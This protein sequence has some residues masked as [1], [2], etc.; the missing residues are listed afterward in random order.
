MFCNEDALLEHKGVRLI[1][2]IPQQDVDIVGLQ[3][4]ICK[5]FLILK[6]QGPSS[7]KFTWQWLPATG[8]SSGILLGVKKDTFMVDDMD[9][10]ELFV[11]MSLT[12][13]RS[14]L[15]WEAIIIYG[16]V[17]QR[18]SEAFLAKLKSKVERS[19][20]P[21]LVGGDFKL[22]RSNEDKS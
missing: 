1:E 6:L 2:Y 20:I 13:R 4:M 14:N 9:R 19:S 22:I 18:R 8:H 5:D 3:E 16:L 7:H 15:S 10:G 12:Y 21:V 17:D 11:S